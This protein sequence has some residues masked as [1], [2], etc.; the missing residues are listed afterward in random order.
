MDV[1]SQNRKPWRMLLPLA[2]VLVL[3]GLW[4]AYWYVAAGLA[5]TELQRQRARLA[6]QGLEIG[7]A[8]EDWGGYPFRFEFA[9]TSPVLAASRHELSA[10]SLRAYAQAYYPWHVLLLVDGP[11]RLQPLAG[12]PLVAS[13]ETLRA[14][15]RFRD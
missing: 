14:S 8:S 9:C 3:A 12:A 5:R 1:N 10:A 6:A 4:S 7:C 13:H 2:A 15:I 11:T